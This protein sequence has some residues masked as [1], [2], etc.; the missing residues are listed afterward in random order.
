MNRPIG[1]HKLGVLTI[2]LALALT[3]GAAAASWSDF[4]D[5]EFTGVTLDK[6]LQ[7]D[8]LDYTLTISSNPTMTVGSKTYT[9]NWIQSFYVLSDKAGGTFVASNGQGNND[10]TWDSKVNRGG[11][12]SGWTGQGNNRIQ[13]GQS[14]T[15]HFGTFD[16]K[17]NPLTG[18]FHVSYNDGGSTKT[19]WFRWRDTVKVALVPEPGSLICFGVGAVS[20][21]SLAF[22]RRRQTSN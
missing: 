12:I 3:T 20:F 5:A 2:V 1:I 18:G 16:P 22:R 11:Q 10:W 15:F 14:E 17:G 9:V 7:V 4:R 8:V 19:A 21:F 6:P 13:P